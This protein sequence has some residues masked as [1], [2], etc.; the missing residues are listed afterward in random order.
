MALYKL[1][2]LPGLVLATCACWHA[3]SAVAR[4][5]PTKSCSTLLW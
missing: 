4:N 1:T 3:V 5:S 2:T